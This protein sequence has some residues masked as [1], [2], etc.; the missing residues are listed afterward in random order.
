MHCMYTTGLQISLYLDV[1]ARF[2]RRHYP[3]QVPWYQR[4]ITLSQPGRPSPQNDNQILIPGRQTV[5]LKIM[6]A[7]FSAQASL[8]YTP[9]R[10]RVQVTLRK[11]HSNALCARFS[12]FNSGFSRK[13]RE[14]HLA[15]QVGLYSSQASCNEIVSCR[16]RIPGRI[17]AR[18]AL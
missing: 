9:Y 16:N 3:D 10:G 12:P 2:L 15:L 17:H 7:I 6:P 18:F 1:L 8:L 4:S 14:K 5:N 11:S 13:A